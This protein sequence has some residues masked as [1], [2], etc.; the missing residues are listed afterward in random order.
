VPRLANFWD[1]DFPAGIGAFVFGFRGTKLRQSSPPK[2]ICLSK[3]RA[4]YGQP[5]VWTV[6]TQLLRQ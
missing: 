6:D 5:G 4:F 1:W 2:L 3:T